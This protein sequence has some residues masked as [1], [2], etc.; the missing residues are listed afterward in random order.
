MEIIDRL[1]QIQ[2]R[3]GRVH[4]ATDRDRD[5]REVHIQTGG[6]VVHDSKPEAEY[7]E[8]VHKWNAIRRAAE[9]AARFAD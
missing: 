5:G 3:H 7:M 6:G 4:R 2:R 1:L 8:T 9:N